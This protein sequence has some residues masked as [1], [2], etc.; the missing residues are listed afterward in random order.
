M[1]AVTQVRDWMKLKPVVVREDGAALEALD[2]MVE[3]GIRHLPVVDDGNRV[4]GILTIDDLRGA[5]PFEVSWKRPPDPL[6]RSDGRDLRVSDAMT[7]APRTVHPETTL[8]RAV[9]VLADD[10]IGCLPVVDA[11][12][13]LV[14]I[15]SEVDA[16]HALDALLH[17]G[18]VPA[19]PRREDPESVVD[20]L[21]AE[22]G[23]LVEQLAKWK[24]TER[25]L[26]EEARAPGDLA[27]HAI[28]AAAITAIE[29]LSAR[30]ERR[31]RA[32]ELAIERA[33]RGRLGIC[34]RCGG[35]IPRT[36][37]RAI[38]EATLCMGCARTSADGE[39]AR[40]D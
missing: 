16:L 24:E 19:A 12:E 31:M 22:R 27:D 30:A 34:E 21:W 36:R 33:E 17:S 7:W 6:D 9:R 13:Q 37:L 25:V 39:R 35:R 2:L 1:A 10:R 40:E 8:E 3:Q 5:F 20:E 14:G 18:G 32:I 38:P 26:H 4:I 29:P 23:R 28:D 11:R 15:L